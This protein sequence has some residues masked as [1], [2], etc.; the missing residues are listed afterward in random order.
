MEG[1]SKLNLKYKKISK[2]LKLDSKNVYLYYERGKV[3]I[4]LKNYLAA[5]DDLSKSLNGDRKSS[6]DL[7]RFQTV[8]LKDIASLFFNKEQDWNYIYI[9]ERINRK[10]ELPA[11]YLKFINAFVSALDREFE[12]AS[13]LF[14]DVK[15]E[16][17]NIFEEN[18]FLINN[19]PIEMQ[20]LL[21]VSIY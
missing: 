19:L 11:V 3:N 18:K 12:M 13:S 10:I 15:I 17:I 7:F 16:N 20:L 21:K 5:M 2:A 6:K 8:F 4:E 1:F 14:E 9:P